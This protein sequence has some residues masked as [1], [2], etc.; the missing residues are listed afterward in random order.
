M[1]WK[2]TVLVLANVTATSDEFVEALRKRAAVEAVQYHL[3]VPAT[4]FGGG[5]EAA[6]SRSR[7]RS[8]SSAQPDSRPTAR[9][10]TATRSSPSARRGIRSDSM[11]S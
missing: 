1:A 6:Q 9:S 5:R 4:A 8:Q 10:A 2:R 7:R 11:R 3:I